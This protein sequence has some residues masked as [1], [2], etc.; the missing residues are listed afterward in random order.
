M[1]LLFLALLLAV[2]GMVKLSGSARAVSR[3]E[4]ARRQAPTRARK[5]V[6]PGTVTAPV[7]A[8]AVAGSSS[9]AVAG[10]SSPAPAQ[11]DAGRDAPDRA[12]L[13]SD[14]DSN[15]RAFA[16]STLGALRPVE[17]ETITALAQALVDADPL[18]RASA[19]DALGAIGRR[20][21]GVTAALRKTLSDEDPEVREA[22]RRALR[23]LR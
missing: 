20:A 13:L 11:A 2:G 18:V 23:R 12:V 6:M 10:G 19:A 9:P 5:R 22:G 16:A 7:A 15:A 3:Y 1:G 4:A 14:P 8:P 17:P 21:Q